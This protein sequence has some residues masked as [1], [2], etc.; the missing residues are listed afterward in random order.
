MIV[1]LGAERQVAVEGRAADP[2]RGRDL[3]HRVLPRAHR[4]GGGELL[5]GD[6]ARAAARPAR[7]RSLMISF[8]NSARAPKM[9]N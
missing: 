1:G 2:E 4:L 6:E 8:S 7:V 3:G 5:R 9:W